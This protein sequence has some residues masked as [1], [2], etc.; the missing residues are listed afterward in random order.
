[1]CGI[2]GI[3]SKEN[4]DTQKAQMFEGIMKEIQTRGRDAFGF[5]SVPR[6]ANFKYIGTVTEFLETKKSIWR[7]ITGQKMV[8]AHTRMETKGTKDINANNHPFETE[9][10]ALAH[11]GCINNDEDL[12]KRY[13][14]AD[15]DGKDDIETDSYVIIKLIQHYYDKEKNV[16]KAIQET[17]KKITGSYACWLLHKESGD[18]YLFRYSQPLDISYLTD[19]KTLIFASGESYCKEPIIESLEYRKL[20]DMFIEP[21]DKVLTRELDEEVIY[22]IP[23]EK[24]LEKGYKIKRFKFEHCDISSTTYYGND[25]DNIQNSNGLSNIFEP[26]KKDTRGIIVT[27]DDN[28]DNDLVFPP[29]QIPGDFDEQQRQIEEYGLEIVWLNSLVRNVKVTKIPI[30]YNERMKELGFTVRNDESV[31]IK[32][33]TLGDFISAFEKCYK[34]IEGV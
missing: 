23:G 33:K 4:I 1:M 15:K 19:Q 26:A 32:L 12:K 34:D 16:I 20:F 28:N 14:I 5:I 30:V 22:M 21:I 24:F 10:F 8:L 25:T 11:N 31:V 7:R 6:L 27:N 29:E 17:C 2:C 18:I 13:K 3:I 9:N